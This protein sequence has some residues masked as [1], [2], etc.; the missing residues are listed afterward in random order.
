MKIWQSHEKGDDKV[1][2]YFNNT[3]YRINPK[4]NEVD[5]I[6]AD[7]LESKPPTKNFTSIPL[8]YLREINLE[9][10]KNYIALLFNQDSYEHLK[11][12]NQE[13]RTEIFEYFKNNIQ[14]VCST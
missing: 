10:N 7:C 14:E 11:V 13:K 8:H 4:S 3:I 2:A 5:Q 1:I 12:Q 9:D 6:I